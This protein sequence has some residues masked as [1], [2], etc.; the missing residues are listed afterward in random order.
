MEPKRILLIWIGRL[1]D[2]IVS[3]PL[4]AFLR[5]TFPNSQI[6]LLVRSGVYELAKLDPHIDQCFPLTPVTP[7]RLLSQRTDVAID[8]NPSYSRTSGILSLLTRASRRIS[9]AKKLGDVFY[10]RQVPFN[11]TDHMLERYQ[12]LAQSLGGSLEPLPKVYPQ[13]VHRQEALKIL[14]GLDLNSNKK[15]IGIHPGNFKKFDHRWP[16]DKFVQLTRNLLQI[17]KLQLLYL[18][19]PGEERR[20]YE[21]LKEI[22]AKIPQIPALPLPVLAAFLQN[23]SLLIANVTGTLHLAAAVGTP[24]LSFHSQYTYQVWKPLQQ[25]HATLVSK[26]WGSCRDIAVEEAWKKLY[27]IVSVYG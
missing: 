21:I 23:L 22:P 1:G 19:G 15:M 7:L 20:V 8:L 17:P 12:K 6:N 11:E 14:K 3:T 25:E 18:T 5:K 26:S 9:F 2:F 4:I 27:Q 16:E 24:T 10:T 13:T